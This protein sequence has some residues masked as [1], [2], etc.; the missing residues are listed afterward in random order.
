MSDGDLQRAHAAGAST[1]KSVAF[2]SCN[3]Y[4][5]ANCVGV[6]VS[7]NSPSQ[8][9]LSHR[10]CFSDQK[11]QSGWFWPLQLLLSLIH[12]SKRIKVKEGPYKDKRDRESVKGLAPVNGWKRLGV[13]LMCRNDNGILSTIQSN[14][15]SWYSL[16]FLAQLRLI[17]RSEFIIMEIYCV[18]SVLLYAISSTPLFGK[19]PFC[20]FWYERDSDFN[21]IPRVNQ[22]ETFL[23][24]FH[25]H[26]QYS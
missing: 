13:S 1:I 12:Q 10:F 3:P 16:L 14:T 7:N 20:N 25:H 11:K 2:R 18:W 22:S 23:M 17:A 26:L 19:T 24:K 21:W 9:V 6:Q 5:K 4:M 8:V 15:T